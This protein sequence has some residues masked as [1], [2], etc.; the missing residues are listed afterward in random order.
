[1][2]NLIVYTRIYYWKE[3]YREGI[4]GIEKSFSESFS[5]KFLY[6][7]WNF[8]TKSETALSECLSSWI[9]MRRQDDSVQH[10]E[11]P[12]CNGYKWYGR[13]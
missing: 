2:P 3:I 10:G 4:D 7:T 5:H 13:E 1:M 6:I 11:T 9:V 12:D 8:L